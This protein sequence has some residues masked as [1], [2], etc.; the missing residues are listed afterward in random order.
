ME[1]PLNFYRKIPLTRLDFRGLRRNF[2][3]VFSVDFLGNVR[4]GN[5]AGGLSVD[6]IGNCT[7]GNIVPIGQINTTP[8]NVR[9]GLGTFPIAQWGNP[10]Q[11]TLTL[12]GPQP[13]IAGTNFFSF[14]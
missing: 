8:A 11:F 1:K 12:L 13:I 7:V 5:N 2:F 3:F 9:I 4:A 6:L 14:T 10:A